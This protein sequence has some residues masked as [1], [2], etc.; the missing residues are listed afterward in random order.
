MKASA[1]RSRGARNPPSLEA[2]LDTST[3]NPGRRRG[4]ISGGVKEPIG[5]DKTGLPEGTAEVWDL[6]EIRPRRAADPNQSASKDLRTKV[7]SQATG[8]VL[9]YWPLK[10]FGLLLL[11][12]SFDR[13]TD[14][15][16]SE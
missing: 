13:V 12:S 4:E 7:E 8:L 3:N 10:T 11:V 15:L 6:G 9:S 2:S 5:C 16:P 1:G 14:K